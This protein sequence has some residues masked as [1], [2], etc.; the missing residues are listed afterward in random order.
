MYLLCF[1]VAF[2]T[3]EVVDLRHTDVDINPQYSDSIDVEFL[4]IHLMFETNPALI[5]SN[6]DRSQKESL[7]PPFPRVGL[8]AFEAG[9]DEVSDYLQ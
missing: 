9:L 7:L 4:T 5:G 8:E 1:F 2:L 3:D 6:A